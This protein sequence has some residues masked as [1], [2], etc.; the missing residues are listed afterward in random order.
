[1]AVCGDGG[2]NAMDCIM[3]G[4]VRLVCLK[5]EDIPNFIAAARQELKAD[6]NLKYIDDLEGSVDDKKGGVPD[7]M[8]GQRTSYGLA[9]LKDAVQP[10]AAA[11]ASEEMR[12]LSV[13]FDDHGERHM[14]WRDATAKMVEDSF[15]DWPITGPRTML[16]LCKFWSKQG[17]SPST[18]LEKHLATESY[19]VTDRSVHELRA[20]AE[21]MD[22]AG[23][24][25]QLNLASLAS[26]ELVARR[27]QLILAAHSRNAA[28][29]DYDGSEYYEGIEKKRFG[30]AP[31]LSEH[32]SRKMRDDAEIEKQK[33]KARELRTTPTAKAKAS[34]AG[35][36]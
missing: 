32:V 16:W 15:N 21:V 9:D 34:A 4:W 29:P 1:M 20:L 12:T 28:N 27:W 24:Y 11:G 33:N 13:S 10:A 6:P 30:I 31:A 22:T 35:K 18:W 3:G 23:M 8:D 14:T 26:F 25:D 5:E 17:H 19:G 36:Q 7:M 2:N